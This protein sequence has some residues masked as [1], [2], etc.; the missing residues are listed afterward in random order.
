MALSLTHSDLPYPVRHARFSALVEYRDTANAVTNP[1]SPDSELSVDGGGSFTDCAEEVSPTAGHGYL[2]LS[3]AE[4]NYPA[5]KVQCKGTGVVTATF[6]LYPRDFTIIRAATATAGGNSTITLDAGA[7]D[8]NDAYNGAIVRTT[9][10]TGGGGTGGANNQARVI[11]DYVGSTKIATISGTWETNPSSDTTFDLL[12][13]PE[14]AAMRT[15]QALPAYAPGGANGL[16][17]VGSAM[18]VAALSGIT[19]LAAWLRGIVRLDAMDTTAK[20]ELNTG[21][22]TYDEADQSLQAVAAQG[23]E[24][25]GAQALAQETT[26]K[27]ETTMEES[28]TPGV[29]EFTAAAL[30]NAPVST[31]TKEQVAAEVQVNAALNTTAVLTAVGVVDTAVGVVGTAVG[32]VATAL[33]E[34]PTDED[35]QANALAALVQHTAPTLAQIPDAEAIQTAVEEG[36]AAFPVPKVADLVTAIELSDWGKALHILA[37]LNVTGHVKLNAT[38]GTMKVYDGEDD[39]DPL[40]VTITGLK[41]GATLM[42]WT[43]HVE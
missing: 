20:T 32:A 12:G 9:G 28:A 21:D 41:T 42:D 15:L 24:M 25:L 13:T 31:L 11:L 34:L 36:L 33:G 37:R 38:N 5:V 40:L 6:D 18:V 27:I 22:G 7:S 39:T 14:W 3:G 1:T 30:A 2:T 10:G 17:I 8:Q 4:T 43:P 23:E 19:S 29:Y 16:A 35:V 26:D